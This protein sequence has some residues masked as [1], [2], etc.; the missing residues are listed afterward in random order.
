MMW[1]TQISPGRSRFEYWTRIH[2]A[3]FH[4]LKTQNSRHEPAKC[5]YSLKAGSVVW[6]RNEFTNFY[7]TRARADVPIWTHRSRFASN[8]LNCVLYPLKKSGIT[9]KMAQIEIF[10]IYLNRARNFIKAAEWDAKPGLDPRI[11]T[12]QKL[13]KM[14]NADKNRSGRDPDPRIKLNATQL[15]MDPDSWIRLC[16]FL[17]GPQIRIGSVCPVKISSSGS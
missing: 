9:W 1:Q 3:A 6:C 16:E 7:G 17:C 12:H 10:Y 11:R 4:A 5:G 8:R 2:S 14:Q 13:R 15:G